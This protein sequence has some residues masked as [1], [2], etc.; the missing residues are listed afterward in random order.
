VSARHLN[1]AGSF[2]VWPE[3]SDDPKHEVGVVVGINGEQY[4]D[5]STIEIGV[6]HKGTGYY[7]RLRVTDLWRALG[8]LESREA[9]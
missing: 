4:D 7:I 1:V 6:S 2:V 9:P 3:N 8:R 5:G